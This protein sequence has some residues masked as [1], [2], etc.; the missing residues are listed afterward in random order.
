VSSRDIRLESLLLLA[1]KKTQENYAVRPFYASPFAA[2]AVL[3]LLLELMM[4]REW[5]RVFSLA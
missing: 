1:F 2:L 4:K 5:G 3:A